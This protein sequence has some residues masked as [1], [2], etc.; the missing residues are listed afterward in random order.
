MPA[1]GPTD[2]LDTWLRWL[3]TLTPTEIDLG[4]ARVAA[5]LDRLCLPLPRRVI[6]VA[7]TNGKGSSVALLH[8]FFRERGATTGAYTSPHIFRYEERIRINDELAGPDQIVAAFCAIESVRAGTPLTYFEYGTLAAL[9][10]FAEAG[11]EVWVL[12]VGLG[13]RLDAVNA[14]EPDACLIT[15]VSL[16]HQDWLGDN[17]EAIAAEKAGVM[18]HGIPVVF[19]DTQV[20][21][22]IHAAAAESGAV[23]TL[24]GD[25]YSWRRSGERRWS[26]Q[27]R[28]CTLAAIDRPSLGGEHQIVNAA[29]VLAL[30]EVLNLD[31]LLTADVVNRAMQRTHLAGR[32]ERLVA[33]GR[34]WLLDGA[35]NPAG[36]EALAATLQATRA[37]TPDC[38]IALVLGVLS[39]KD[40][41]AMLAALTGAVDRMIVTTPPSPRAMPAIELLNIASAL[42]ESGVDIEADPTSALSKAIEVTSEQDLIVVAGSFYTL[43]TVHQWLGTATA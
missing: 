3:E 11:L 9:W 18:R 1:P 6:T 2:D 30:L 21:Q 31:A 5:V 22:A 12:E 34:R 28:R 15:N 33:R 35:H 29:G 43:Q 19:A 14:V 16:D 27:G 40:A 38:E 10:L 36:A 24:A 42:G 20:P 4:L 32:Q 26:W 39:D 41:A 13:G 17:V 25:D 7:G 8:A 37:A 23:L